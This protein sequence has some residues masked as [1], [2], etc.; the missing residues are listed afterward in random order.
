MMKRE[1]K[2]GKS[3]KRKRGMKRKTKRRSSIIQRR[4]SETHP[5]GGAPNI[6]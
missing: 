6:R 1:R 4:P 5:G 3:R 2:R